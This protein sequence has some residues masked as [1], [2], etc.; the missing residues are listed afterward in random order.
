[1]A[2]TNNAP[3]YVP[4]VPSAPATKPG[5]TPTVPQGVSSAFLALGETFW[6]FIV[7]A[8]LA[9]LFN[10]VASFFGQTAIK[11]QKVAIQD[12]FSPIF[13]RYASALGLQ[14]RDNHFLQFDPE[15]VQR[16]TLNNP[17]YAGLR[18]EFLANEAPLAAYIKKNPGAGIS[19]RVVNQFVTNAAINNWSPEVTR[20]LWNGL[21]AKVSATT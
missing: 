21:L 11:S 6:P 16:Y 13:K 4:Y 8:A 12:F 15:G 5:A 14:L 19:E 10:F 18:L 7:V 9:E 17:I 2:P 1:M 3:T 20:N